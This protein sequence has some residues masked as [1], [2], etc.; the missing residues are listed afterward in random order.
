MFP[1]TNEEVGSRVGLIIAMDNG[2]ALRVEGIPE[3]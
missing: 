3:T 2:V 1:F